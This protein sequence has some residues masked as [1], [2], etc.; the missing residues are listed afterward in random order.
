M[1]TSKLVSMRIPLRVAL[2]FGLAGS[3]MYLPGAGATAVDRADGLSTALRAVTAGPNPTPK[4]DGEETRSYTVPTRHGPLYLEVVHPTSGGELLRAHGILTLSPYS[5]ISRNDQAALF[6]PRGYARMQADVIG[7]GN[8]GGCYDYGGKR[9]KET[10]YD[11]VQWIAKQPW[12]LGRVGMYGASYDGTTATAT[13]VTRPPALATI[14]PEAAISRWYDYAYSGGIRYTVNNEARG[15]QGA[16]SVTDQGFD[17]PLAFDVGFSTPPPTDVTNP[18]YAERLLATQPLCE[19]VEHLQKGYDTTPDYDAFWKE[20]DYAAEASKIT[21]P[22]MVVHNWGDWNVKQDTAHRLYNSL[23]RSAHKRLYFGH[24][25]D[26]HGRPGGAYTATLVDWMDRWVGGVQNGI[27]RTLPRVTSQTADAAGAGEFLTAKSLA[28]SKVLLG[29]TDGFELVPGAGTGAGSASIAITG[30]GTESQALSDLAPGSHETYAAL[31]SAPLAQDV[32]IVGTPT[33]RL[34]VDSGRTWLTLAVSLV[35]LESE[36]TASV[37]VTRGW[38]DT[39]YEKGLDQQRPQAP[40]KRVHGVTLKPMDYTF[41]KGHRIGLVVQGE[42]TEW[43]IPKAYDGTP[44]ATC[45]GFDL[46]VG[47]GTSLTL[48]VVSGTAALR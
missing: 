31:Q 44:C 27:E 17:T 18:G 15:N 5:V 33:V 24:R 48:P 38:L 1:L 10:G 43:V 34:S 41:R 23:T 16:G 45:A 32:R 6:V 25:W 30:T 40:G 4:V 14:V 21:I 19:E 46:L 37:A 8:S 28:S 13:A 22:V 9:E 36:G 39:R 20:R 11:L 42:Q 12:S 7:T 2:A 35:D 26:N 47:P 3:L 29:S